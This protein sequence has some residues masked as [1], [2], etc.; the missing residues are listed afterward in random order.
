MKDTADF[1]KDLL[2]LILNLRN[3]DPVLEAT[4]PHDEEML[5][6]QDEYAG[7]GNQIDDEELRRS[8]A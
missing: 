3:L 1:V 4:A 6:L 5:S 8:T 7:Y 2:G